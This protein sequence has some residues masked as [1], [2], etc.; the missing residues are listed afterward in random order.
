MQSGKAAIGEEHMRGHRPSAKLRAGCGASLAAIILAAG[1]AFAQT[2]DGQTVNGGAQTDPP[3]ASLEDIVVTGTSIRGVP[4][5]GSNLISVTRNDIVTHG[6]ANTPDLSASI[7]QLSSFNTAPQT[8]AGTGPGLGSFAPA[9]R[10][11]PAS[12]TLPLMNG[13]RLV[14]AG[15]Q[16]TNPDYPLIPNLAVQR[17]EVVADGASAI[18]GSDAVA[19]VVNFITRQHVDGV[20]MSATYG[21]GDDYYSGNLG[22]LFGRDWGSGSFLAAYQYSENDNITGGERDYR[23][24]DYTPWGGVDARS[25]AC[26]EPN[27]YPSP[28][29]A[30]PYA[31]DSETGAFGAAGTQNRCDAAAGADLFPASKIHAGYFSGRQALNDRAS[32]WGEILYSDRHDDIRVAPQNVYAYMYCPGYTINPNARCPIGGVHE[33]VYFNSGTLLNTDHFTNTNDKQVGNS[34]FGADFKM[35]RELNLSIYGTVAWAKNQSYV[36]SLSQAA[37][38][39]YADVNLDPFGGATPQQTIDAILAYD[40]YVDVIERHDVRAAGVKLDGPLVDL[41]GGQ[42]RFALGAEARYEAFEQRGYYLSPV[43]NVDE[44]MERDIGAVY[45]ELFVP[46]FGDG[47]RAPL[48]Q[49]LTLSLSGRYDDYSDFGST[50]NPKIGLNWGV[51][52]GLALRGSYGTSFR[53]PGLRQL[54]A[55]IGSY[56]TAAAGA[57]ALDASLAG[58]QTV[59]LSGGNPDLGP[60]KATTHSFGLDLTP[61]SL[62]GL[63]A[64]LTYYNV[65]YSDVIASPSLPQIFADTTLRDS[66]V[67][68]APAY[69]AG[70]DADIDSLLSIAIPSGGSPTVGSPIYLVDRRNQNLSSLTTDGLDLDVNYR[71]DT[72]FGWMFAG[73]V[74]NYVLNYHTRFSPE[75]AESD[76]LNL[77][78]PRWTGRAS[79]AANAGAISAAAF[80]NY[81]AGVTNNYSLAAGGTAAYEADPYVTVDLRVSWRLPDAGWARNTTLALQVNDLFD[82]DPPFFPATDGVGGAYNP[83]GR[84]VALNLHK[85]F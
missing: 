32:I 85:S 60:E 55:T 41:P 81:R 16:V 22:I 79:L 7:P 45:G 36:F 53:A 26:F 48:V 52:E 68:Y 54:G 63:R 31:Y 15:V 27:V 84:F 9:L 61:L 35:P 6:G 4:P 83:I 14:G 25:N 23:V 70:G 38:Q 44:N 80:V 77:G 64:S 18:Y 2:L 30:V 74:G 43:F 76:Y 66:L 82:Q 47:N 46:L 75:A 59:Y 24:L 10:S 65:D 17:I 67:Y 8:S 13:R 57:A 72:G 39:S 5:V 3:A 20:E 37:I 33:F 51:M 58:V 21:A 12:A 78:L 71:W 29:Y 56:Y 42:L 40:Y 34:S 73:F 11:L 50:T 49:S 69:A 28:S 1:P 62:P 19:G